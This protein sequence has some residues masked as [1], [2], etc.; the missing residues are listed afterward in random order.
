MEI[1][2]CCYPFPDSWIFQL[3]PAVGNMKN[4]TNYKHLGAGFVLIYVFISLVALCAPRNG[5]AGSYGN[6]V[7]N[8][9]RNCGCTTLYSIQQCVK[10]PISPHPHQ[11][12]LLSDVFIV[13]ILI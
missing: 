13:V 12:L 1:Q 11:T 5:M 2:P 9:F 7:L 6:P 8:Y 4:A 10:V 3:F